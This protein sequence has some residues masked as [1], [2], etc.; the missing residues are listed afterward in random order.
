VA[1]HGE[2]WTIDLELQAGGGNAGILSTESVAESPYIG[3][4]LAEVEVLAEER[5]SARRWDRVEGIGYRLAHI[6]ESSHERVQRR[7]CCWQ[8][9]WMRYAC[10]VRD[11]LTFRVECDQSI[12]TSKSLSILWHIMHVHCRR[13][14]VLRAAACRG[15]VRWTAATPQTL[16]A[17]DHIGN[18]VFSA[19]FAVI[20]HVHANFCLLLYHLRQSKLTLTWA[21]ERADMG[22]TDPR[23]HRI[24]YRATRGCLLHEHVSR[25]FAA[26]CRGLVEKV[27]E[28]LLL[29][30]GDPA[31]EPLVQLLPL[32][33]VH[34][35][36]ALRRH[37]PPEVFSAPL[38]LHARVRRDGRIAL[39]E[40]QAGGD[41]LVPLPCGDP[42]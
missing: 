1:A 9:T 7:D 39:D 24:H 33:A 21:R 35:E 12:P 34:L 26:P 4:V 25:L 30:H 14:A 10:E 15:A 37:R 36:E 28:L 22:G 18:V 16:D 29:G 17:I 20:H 2:V 3:I 31:I 19:P 5:Q 13:H 41:V 23:L 42:H 27:R 32:L 8:I 11:C 6:G 40:L 38:N